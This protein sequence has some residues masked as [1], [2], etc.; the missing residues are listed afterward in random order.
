[1][2]SPIEKSLANVSMAA[3]PGLF[4][5]SSSGAAKLGMRFRHSHLGMTE[6][7]T[8]IY[9]SVSKS[10]LGYSQRVKK[11]TGKQLNKKMLAEAVVDPSVVGWR[12][13][14]RGGRRDGMHHFGI[15]F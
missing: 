4:C 2:G 1:M 11:N 13:I 3:F 15:D 7:E 6:S 14:P 8:P 5:G 9:S 10:Q 12:D